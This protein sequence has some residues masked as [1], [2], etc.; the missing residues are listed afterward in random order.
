MTPPQVDFT[1]I[2][3]HPRA[4]GAIQTKLAIN[5]PGDSYEQEADR[6]AGQVMRMAAA[7]VQSRS[8]LQVRRSCSCGGS[9]ADCRG[10]DSK[11]K[12]KLQTERVAG[13]FFGQSIAP[14]SVHRVL[15]SDSQPLDAA[16]RAFMEPRFGYDFSQ[17][18]VHH[19]SAAGQSARDVHAHAYTVGQSIVFAEGEFAPST[20]KG[21]RLLA[22]ELTHV[23]QQS[24][25]ALAA[26][27]G[28]LHGPQPA[29]VSAANEPVLRRQVAEPAV[30]TA[31]AESGPTPSA[32]VYDTYNYDNGVEKDDDEQVVYRYKAEH[33]QRQIRDTKKNE[34]EDTIPD[35]STVQRPRTDNAL[36][37]ANPHARYLDQATNTNL[38]VAF[39][40]D[41]ANRYVDA[42]QAELERPEPTLFHGGQAP[43][44]VTVRPELLELNGIRY[45]PHEFHILDAIEYGVTNAKTF[46]EAMTILTEATRDV[47]F[48]CTVSK[49]KLAPAILISKWEPMRS[50]EIPTGF[51]LG[52]VE[53]FKAFMRGYEARERRMGRTTKKE[54]KK[55]TR[56]RPEVQ[57]DFEPRY[58]PQKR[59]AKRERE[60][61]EPHLDLPQGKMEHLGL[62]ELLVLGSQIAAYPTEIIGR[63]RTSAYERQSNQVSK[64]FTAVGA[65]MTQKVLNA[66]MKMLTE[67]NKCGKNADCIERQRKRVMKP[68]WA[69]DGT[70]KQMDV[71]HIVELQVSFLQGPEAL[72]NFANYELLD[73]STN[74]S[75]GST[76]DKSI[77][78]ERNRM[79]RECPKQVPNWSEVPLVF[80][81][82]VFVGG[83]KGPGERWTREQILAGDHLKAYRR[84]K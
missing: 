2:P 1:R 7:P 17:V 76:L 39:Q 53:R 45:Y 3:V 20:D 69:P 13:N 24:G 34:E 9:C 48:S 23:V 57:T 61:C 71:D 82:P 50:V 36:P 25:G 75:V 28:A 54:K 15:R 47:D 30:E 65:Q 78:A 72:D 51:D 79:K 37:T 41:A 4:D 68:D 59:G 27:D 6:V 52:G 60:R 46:D 64:W 14:P 83:G 81:P 49:P 18:R 67:D 29:L 38:D 8:E 21:R 16:T 74:S 12:G 22:H 58:K 33:E 40:V 11:A 84:K 10:K 63:R 73:S 5:Q 35:G 80:A 32:I 56:P 66:G 42:K 62:Y 77:Q 44:F 26:A 55:D 31:G 19:D 43:D 70:K